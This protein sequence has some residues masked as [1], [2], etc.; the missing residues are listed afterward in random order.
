MARAGGWGYIFGDEGGAFAIGRQAL[1]AALRAEEG[2]GRETSLAAM[3]LE[4]TGAATINE[5]LHLFYTPDWPRSRVATLAAQVDHA[6]QNSDVVA[7]KILTQAAQELALLA[8]AVRRQLFQSG[9]S[10]DV[11]YIGGVFESGAVRERFRQLVELEEGARVS[12][13]RFGPAEGALL[14]ALRMA[15][16]TAQL[17]PKG[18]A[19]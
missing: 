6:A 4:A 11:A 10:V 5:V 12:A 1:R 19:L 13:P 15:G 17:R 9:E 18:S 3:L 8:A 16:V 2:W 7:Q 14:E